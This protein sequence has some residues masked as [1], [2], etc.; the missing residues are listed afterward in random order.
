MTSCVRSTAARDS[1]VRLGI[2]RSFRIAS[3]NLT[4]IRCRGIATGVIDRVPHL[5]HGLGVD[6]SE[7][8]FVGD[9]Q[10][11][12]VAGAQSAGMHGLLIDNYAEGAPVIETAV[13]AFVSASRDAR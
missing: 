13:L 1:G 4:T 11:H 2:S 8:L 3:H 10:A 7:C 12:D 9:D 6:A 5:L